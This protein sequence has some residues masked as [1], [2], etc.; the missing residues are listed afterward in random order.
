VLGDRDEPDEVDVT[1]PEARESDLD[2]E[3]ETPPS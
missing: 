3:E 1:D 2:T